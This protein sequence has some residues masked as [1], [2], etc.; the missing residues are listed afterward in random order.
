M[1]VGLCLILLGFMNCN[2]MMLQVNNVQRTLV[3]AWGIVR[4]T[5]VDPTFNNQGSTTFV[6]K[7][8]LPNFVCQSQS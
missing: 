8:L 4:E 3:E 5:Y 1:R 6:P 2:E 7:I